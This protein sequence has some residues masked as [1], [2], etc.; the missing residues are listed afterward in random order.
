MDVQLSVTIPPK[1]SVPKFMEYL[2]R[3]STLMLYDM[4][5]N[6]QNKWD[7]AFWA[8]GYY[9]LTIG[10]VTEEAIKKYIQEQAKETRKED[11][12]STSL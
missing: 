7:E 4:H 3:K 10:N 1:Y 6:L 5:P 11:S 9:V 8:R 2:K 12:T